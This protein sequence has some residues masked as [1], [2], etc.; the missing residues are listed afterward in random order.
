MDSFIGWIG[1]KKLLREEVVK[2]FPK[3][4]VKKYVEAFGGAGWVLFHKE[5]HAET[6]IYND[7]NSEL[8]NLFKCLKYHMP[9][10][11]RELGFILN[12]R[13]MFGEFKE[14][15]RTKG[16]TEIQR[17]ARFFILVKTSYG[18]N[19]RDYGGIGKYVNKLDV[20]S[21]DIVKRLS[22]VVIENKS[23]DELIKMTDRETTLFYL[24]P[25]YFGAEKFYEGGFGEAEHEK[26]C[27]ILKG[28][29]GRFVLSY[30]DCDYIRDMYKVFRVEGVVRN[31]NLA[32]RYD[33]IDK[34]IYR[35][36][37][38]RNY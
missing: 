15:L 14:Q 30:N 1:G 22:K 17:A 16:M 33:E 18:C 13:E 21:E 24:D 2:R 12:S 35:E 27:D 38:I 3:D 37:I 19:S 23:Y 10:V 36:V 34:R 32:N 4:G 5:R 7:I 9:E 11:Q 29:K 25:P 8:V 28:I 6:E 20:Y 26:L 31:S